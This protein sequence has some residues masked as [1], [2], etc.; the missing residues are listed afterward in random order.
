MHQNEHH[1]VVLARDRL[2]RREELLELQ[3]LAVGDG[4]AEIPVHRLVGKLHSGGFVVLTFTHAHRWYTS[5][6]WFRIARSS[7][8]QACTAA[9]RDYT[10]SRGPR[11]GEGLPCRDRGHR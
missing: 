1:L 6:G 7:R 8:R 5:V 10:H 3:I 9:H 2:L 4:G 11:P